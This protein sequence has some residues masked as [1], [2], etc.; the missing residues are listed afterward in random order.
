MFKLRVTGT[1]SSTFAPGPVQREIRV[2]HIH[3]DVSTPIGTLEP[4]QTD[5]EILGIGLGYVPL[6]VYTGCICLV[7]PWAARADGCPEHGLQPLTTPRVNLTDTLRMAYKR[8]D[9]DKILPRMTAD[10]VAVAERGLTEKARA[11]VR[12]AWKALR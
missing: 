6:P 4:V 5:P 2:S 1:I 7:H 12:A 9:L 3:N 10:E 8:G 11:A